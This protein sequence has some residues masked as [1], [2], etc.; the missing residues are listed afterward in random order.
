[1]HECM[2]RTV[3]SHNRL[4][5][6]ADPL[7]TFFFL[8]REKSKGDPPENE[9]VELS[10]NDVDKNSAIAISQIKSRRE[11]FLGLNSQTKVW[12][13]TMKVEM[14]LNWGKIG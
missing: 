9:L 12:E 6:L 4:P 7:E 5:Q 8:T 1:M 2:S 13:T 14:V 10:P 11:N 3:T